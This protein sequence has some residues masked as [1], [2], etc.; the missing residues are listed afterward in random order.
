VSGCR[1]SGSRS[2]FAPLTWAYASCMHLRLPRLSCVR[3]HDPWLSR[4]AVGPA[5]G[6]VDTSGLRG[7]RPGAHPRTRVRATGAGDGQHRLDL[8]G[9][10][11]L[12]RPLPCWKPSGSAQ[13]FGLS[14]AI[15]S[16]SMRGRP[17][18]TTTLLLRRRGCST[19]LEGACHVA[20][21]C[22]PSP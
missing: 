17:N 14:W 4:A 13:F 16:P 15:C 22:V 9:Y 10:L 1:H 18:R 5:L 6:G 3:P 12:D 20:V 7:C 19:S 2:V 21:R 11:H 8:R